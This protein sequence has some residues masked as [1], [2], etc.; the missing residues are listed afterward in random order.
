MVFFG[1]YLVSI[2]D[3]GRVVIP[4]KI[5]ENLKGD[6][7][8]LTKGFDNCLS[9]YDKDEWNSKTINLMNQ[10]SLLDKE[11]IDKKRYLF[12][13]A[14]QIGIDEQGRFVLP[15]SLMDFLGETNKLV[16]LGV[17]D[18]FE[19]WDAKKWSGY[20]SKLKI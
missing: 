6:L 1:E 9:G 14:N 7:F 4:K 17:G 5:R 19:I 13:G 16:I 3:G 12:S 11:N 18:H 8:V 20:L 2:T 15:K 10:T